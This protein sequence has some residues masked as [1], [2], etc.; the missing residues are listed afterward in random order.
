MLKATASNDNNCQHAFIIKE[1]T[2]AL[3][4]FKILFLS[5]FISK[6]GSALLHF[7]EYIKYF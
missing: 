5:L 1:E 2:R 3:V 4:V 6:I 7:F